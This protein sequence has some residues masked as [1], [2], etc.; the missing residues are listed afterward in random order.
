MLFD[1]LKDIQSKLKEPCYVGKLPTKESVDVGNGIYICL[2]SIS[3]NVGIPK[4]VLPVNNEHKKP[5]QPAER[6]LDLYIVV[7]AYNSD[8]EEGLRD[9]DRVMKYF[10]DNAYHSLSTRRINYTVQLAHLSME[11]NLILA[12]SVLSAGLPGV[13]YK[14]STA[15]L[16][17]LTG[18]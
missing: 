9:M 17:G 1:L 14:V 5:F 4:P 10:A 6:S 3:E 7:A 16:P 8:Y 18:D 13:I 2:L 11:Q 12:Q 15:R